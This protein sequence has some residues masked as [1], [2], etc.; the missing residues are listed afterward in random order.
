MKRDRA[1]DFTIHA[2]VAAAIVGVVIVKLWGI[3]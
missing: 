3:L 2:I 1:A